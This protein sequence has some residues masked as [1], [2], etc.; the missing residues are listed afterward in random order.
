[1]ESLMHLKNTTLCPLFFF[2]K[3]LLDVGDHPT[4]ILFFYKMLDEKALSPNDG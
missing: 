4:I 3:Y 1:M 2:T